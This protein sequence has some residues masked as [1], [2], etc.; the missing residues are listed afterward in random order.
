MA[1]LDDLDHHLGVGDGVEDAV[2]LGTAQS[3]TREQN[4]S[5][6]DQRYLSA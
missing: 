5:A 3:P 4:R 2:R 6:R 1:V